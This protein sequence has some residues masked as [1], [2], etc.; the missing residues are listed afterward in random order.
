MV[1]QRRKTDDDSEKTATGIC[2]RRE[3]C[4]HGASHET[5]LDHGSRAGGDGRR[6]DLGSPTSLP[7]LGM[8]EPRLLCISWR[9]AAATTAAGGGGQGWNRNIRG[10]QPV[11]G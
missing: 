10:G 7:G 5:G 11:V 9:Q 8:W 3:A 6:L 4:R 1:W 2:I